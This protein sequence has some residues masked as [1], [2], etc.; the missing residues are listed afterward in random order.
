[1]KAASSGDTL[2]G[3]DAR[4]EFTFIT[5][6][7][8]AGKYNRTELHAEVADEQQ[9]RD[10]NRPPLDT[11]VVDVNICDC[12]IGA[13]WVGRS[14]EY[15]GNHHSLDGPRRIPERERDLDRRTREVARE[16]I[17]V[18][19]HG[20]MVLGDHVEVLGQG[21][22]GHEARPLFVRRSHATGHSLRCEDNI[23]GSEP[24]ASPGLQERISRKPTERLIQELGSSRSSKR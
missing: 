21:T 15:A 11:L 23:L 22:V 16:S 18:E 4:S 10:A 9:E 17:L 24:R 19:Q 12:E 14:A 13:R 5:L 6:V 2:V 1:M 3:G 7:E 20:A 8:V